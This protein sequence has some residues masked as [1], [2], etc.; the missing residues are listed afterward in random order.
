MTPTQRREQY[1]AILAGD[2]C[3]RAAYVVDPVSARL[4]ED[5]G[6][7]V[8]M[9]GGSMSSVTVLGAPDLMVLTLT[10]F[11]DQV[12]R[13]C[14][15]SDISLMVTAENGYGNAL[16]VMRAVEE[17]ETAGLS[18]LTIDDS[19]LP[20]TFGKP[21]SVEL[22]SL[23]EAVAKMKAALAARQDPTLVI[24]ARTNALRP[25][26]LEETIRRVKAYE[27]AGVDAVYFG[28]IPTLAPGAAIPTSE[29]VRAVHAAIKIPWMVGRFMGEPKDEEFL[30]ANGVR[31]AQQG[32]LAFLAGMKAIQETY[33]ALYDGVSPAALKPK[34]ASAEL[35]SQA[36]RKSRY[37]DWVKNFLN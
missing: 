28:G 32:Q 20:Q 8:G 23:E 9:L 10:E 22:I 29:E 27:Q 7:Q 2:R 35:V 33:K 17:L 11:V 19:L 12:R 4:A 16:S 24:A 31:I 6:F 14:R 26:G 36:T 1:L 21:D 15:A 37:Y 18:A 34:L 30:A 13:I 25:L 3:V 5:V